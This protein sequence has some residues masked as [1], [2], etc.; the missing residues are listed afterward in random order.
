MAEDLC[1]P[2]S[3][4]V[5][6]TA[7]QRAERGTSIRERIVCDDSVEQHVPRNMDCVMDLNAANP[8]QPVATTVVQS[9]IVNVVDSPLND[10]YQ[11]PI[12]NWLLLCVWTW[13]CTTGMQTLSAGLFPASKW[14]YSLFHCGTPDEGITEQSRR[15][16]LTR[17]EAALRAIARS[18][19][20][21]QSIT[22]SL[23][24][25]AALTV[26]QLDDV[27][28]NRVIC[29]LIASAILLA[30]ASIL[31]SF[32]YLLSKEQFITHWKTSEGPYMSFW[33]CISMPLDFTIWSFIFF[34]SAVFILIY[35]RMLPAQAPDATG[36]QRT[37]NPPQPLGPAVVITILTITAACKIYYGL[38]VFYRRR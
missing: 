21:T 23:L 20:D 7:G 4:M 6:T 1:E 38:R 15:E 36:T 2:L 37:M 13:I 28:G 18:W 25:V 8:S 12:L 11:E 17:W 32:V 5:T 19:K 27:L 16:H 9:P 30:L 33:R 35:Q 22:G 34:I 24:L 14:F 10:S 3:Q 31:A 26:L 29:T